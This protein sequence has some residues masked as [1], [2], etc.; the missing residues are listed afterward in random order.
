MKR[1]PIG[2]RRP[3]VGVGRP[4]VDLRAVR[5][6]AQAEAL[7]D[8]IA[9][10]GALEAARAQALEMV[11]QAKAALPSLP[12]GQQLALELVADGVVDRYA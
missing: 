4:E 9:A 5:T 1:G 11:T 2:H 7:C 8:R 10:T 12:A 6:P 3:S